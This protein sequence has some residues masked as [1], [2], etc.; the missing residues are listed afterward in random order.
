MNIGWQ[1]FLSFYTGL[2]VQRK[3][4]D[5]KFQEEKGIGEE[6]EDPQLSFSEDG[7]DEYNQP[8]NESLLPP[9]NQ[10]PRLSTA[11]KQLQN[12]DE[13]KVKLLIESEQQQI[14]EERKEGDNDDDHLN[15]V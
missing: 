1:E 2:N 12:N 10:N 3:Q 9:K 6:T 15:N 5:E 14:E 11:Y 13:E 8:L 4:Y 7:D